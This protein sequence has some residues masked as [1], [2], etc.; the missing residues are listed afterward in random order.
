MLIEVFG[1]GCPRCKTTEKNANDALKELKI[2]GF[3]NH[4]S[5]PK[6]F[7]MR[8]VLMTPG[9]ALNGKLKVYG[10]IPSVE[11]IK[12]WIKEESHEGQQ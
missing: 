8:G 1:P 6:Q 5:D 3:V 9:L 7:A 4:I 2:D 11:E 12:G 10:R